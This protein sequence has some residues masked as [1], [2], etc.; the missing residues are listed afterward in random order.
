M[1]RSLLLA[2]LLACAALTVAA[3]PKPA[4]GPVPITPNPVVPAAPPPPAIIPPLDAAPPH[5]TTPPPPPLVRK[6]APGQITQLPNG[7]R[8][9]FGTGRADFSPSSEAALQ[10]LAKRGR[11]N[12]T[13]VFN[14]YAHA[15]G[16]P[17]DASTPRRLSLERGLA[18]R[19]TLINAGI[20]SIRVFLHAM[21]PDSPGEI[22]PP[23]RVD[24][25]LATLDTA[26]PAM[27]PTPPPPVSKPPPP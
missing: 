16:V 1:R 3:H 26:P 20:P 5:P 19:S 17:E 27:A 11:A 22:V 21:G 8:L 12:P 23:D 9:T 15:P 25:T 18:V 13:L 10:G 14:L 6:D 7:L 4:T 2:P 24:I